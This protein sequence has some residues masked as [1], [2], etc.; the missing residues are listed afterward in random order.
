[1][2]KL[3]DSQWKSLEFAFMCV[4]QNKNPPWYLMTE[5]WTLHYGHPLFIHTFLTY[6]C[7]S[8]LRLCTSL[9]LHT[10]CMQPK[11]VHTTDGVVLWLGVSAIGGEAQQE[12][13]MLTISNY[14]PCYR[15]P[16]MGLLGQILISQ[17]PFTSN[18]SLSNSSRHP[19]LWS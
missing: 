13:S 18:L 14:L 6:T 16:Q 15:L 7:S 17:S 10:W 2:V 11:H 3:D 9:H 12:G 5:V 19:G 1:M 8:W 4:C